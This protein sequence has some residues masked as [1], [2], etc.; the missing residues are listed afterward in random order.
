[1]QFYRIFWTY[2]EPLEGSPKWDLPISKCSVC[3]TARGERGYR[4]PGAS[5]DLHR[6]ELDM[7]LFNPA[8]M[9]QV[10]WEVFREIRS[11]IAAL[12]SITGPLVP[13]TGLGPLV[14]TVHDLDWDVGGVS[15]AVITVLEK[16]LALLQA[17]GI[18]IP[19]TFATQF[20]VPKGKTFVYQELV[21]PPTV[22]L[23]AQYGVRPCPECFRC[24][25]EPGRTA[26]RRRS[27]ADGADFVRGKYDTRVI[28]VSQR[29]KDA[30]QKLKLKGFLKFNQ[31]EL[32]DD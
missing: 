21:L 2:L 3:G 19:E 23:S 11:R 30:V 22:E 7:R 26:Y 16:S 9:A 5:L 6:K 31:I 14:G 28:L 25:V 32:A 17:E 13:G 4:Y 8:K 27:I 20:R 1:M 24:G 15:D 10:P 29:V 18:V 12:T